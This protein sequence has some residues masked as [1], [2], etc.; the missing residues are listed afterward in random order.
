MEGTLLVKFSEEAVAK[1]AARVTRSEPGD[2]P[3]GIG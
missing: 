1:V 2:L 3:I